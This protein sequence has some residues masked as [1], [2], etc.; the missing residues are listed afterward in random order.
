MSTGQN[1]NL[2][3]ASGTIFFSKTYDEAFGLVLEAREY[4]LGPGRTAVR[5]LSSE[6][7]FCYA[8][9]SLRLTTR[10]TESM[11][12][13]MFQRALIEGEITYE[14]VQADECHLQHQKT[15]LPDSES[16]C[17]DLLPV[18]LRSLLVRSESLYR[19]IWRLDQLAI[20]SNRTG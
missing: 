15:C 6:A 10:L 11:S 13:L 19:R 9:E 20:E 2:S 14:E 5:K 16:E 4:L 1:K 3:N 17:D 18:G 8:T 12:W 7:S